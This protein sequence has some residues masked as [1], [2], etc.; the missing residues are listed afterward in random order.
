[1]TKAE[2]LRYLDEIAGKLAELRAEVEML[3]ELSRGITFT[4]TPAPW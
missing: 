1:M 2:I 4:G 3:P